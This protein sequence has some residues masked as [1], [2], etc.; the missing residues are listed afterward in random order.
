MMVPIV[1]CLYYSCI[2]G[3]GYDM[4][5][6]MLKYIRPTHVVKIDISAEKKNL[7]AGLFWLDGEHD[8]MPNLI[9]IKSARRDSLNRS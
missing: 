9:E 5:V 2:L 7:P 8:E 1:L 3:V 6:D 4:L